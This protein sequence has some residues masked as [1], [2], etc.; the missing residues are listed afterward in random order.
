MSN[1][2]QDFWEY[3]EQEAEPQLANR[4]VS[5]RKI[6]E[7][8]DEFE[9]PVTIVETGCLRQIDNYEGDGQSTLL[10]DKYVTW[11]GNGSHVYTVDLDEQAVDACKSIVSQNV[12]VTCSDSVAYLNSIAQ[13]FI[14][15]DQQ[16][17]LL[18]LD[19]YDVDWTY[20]FPSAA[21]HLKELCVAQR[22]INEDTL[23]VVDDCGLNS[24]ILLDDTNNPV[25][26]PNHTQ[27]GGKGRLVAEF[28][29]QIGVQPV[30]TH[31]QVGWIGL[32][33]KA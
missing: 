1:Q 2:T 11:R 30:F 27:V 10:F 28:A 29:Q 4:A 14:D 8:L 23:V 22:F 24:M 6:F 13:G 20:W 33:G 16:I 32:G 26:V 31:Y 9:T 19:S 17:T 21:H 5:F 12:T 18:Y 25:M 3:F 7:Y 15:N